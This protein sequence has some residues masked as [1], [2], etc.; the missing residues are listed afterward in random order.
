MNFNLVISFGKCYA[1]ALV[2]EFV[3]LKE[4]TRIIRVTADRQARYNS[5]EGQV[6]FGAR[7]DFTLD[8]K[9]ISV[10]VRRLGCGFGSTI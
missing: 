8:L 5:Q 1:L 9:R 3:R 6:E 10:S 2:T 4:D 7:A